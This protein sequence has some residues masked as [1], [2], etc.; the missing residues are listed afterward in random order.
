VHFDIIKIFLFSP[1]DALCTV[2]NI[3]AVYE[4]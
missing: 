1:T 2:R 4:A 3:S